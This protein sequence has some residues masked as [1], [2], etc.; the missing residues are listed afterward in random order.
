MSQARSAPYDRSTTT[1]SAVL[2]TT[3]G[4]P[5]RT[6][7]I[8]P[9]TYQL[10]FKLF[11]LRQTRTVEEYTRRFNN[12]ASQ[13]QDVEKHD[14]SAV[15]LPRYIYGLNP[16]VRT[17]V[18]VSNPDSLSTAQAKATSY[19]RNAKAFELI[20]QLYSLR[21]TGTVEEYTRRFNDLNYQIRAIAKDDM[22]GALHTFYIYGLKEDIRANVV[23]SEPEDLFTAREKA[24]L[25]SHEY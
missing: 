19:S 13:I 16:K 17:H 23:N 8:P 15:L 18:L 20:F 5:E 9:N 4:R 24:S 12:L 22:V 1:P 11:S 3:Q 2:A 21:Q 25:F 6:L 7:E 14:I 10:I